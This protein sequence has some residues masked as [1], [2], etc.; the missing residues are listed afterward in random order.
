[1][2]NQKE[3][4]EREINVKAV[5]VQKYHIAIVLYISQQVSQ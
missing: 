4:F 3:T 1:M 2:K 5:R